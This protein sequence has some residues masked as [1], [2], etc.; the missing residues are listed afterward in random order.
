MEERKGRT[1]AWRKK[2]EGSI[3]AREPYR[4]SGEGKAA[5]VI[6]SPQGESESSL[7]PVR[8]KP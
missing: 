8:A 1:R 4:G 6:G 2:D 5:F 3:S 7:E